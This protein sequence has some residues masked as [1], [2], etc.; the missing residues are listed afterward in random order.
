MLSDTI[1]PD[2]YGL[3]KTGEKS[4]KLRIFRDHQAVPLGEEIRLTATFGD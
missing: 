4:A 1:T 3:E 2:G